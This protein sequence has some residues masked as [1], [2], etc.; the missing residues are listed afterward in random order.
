MLI[1]VLIFFQNQQNRGKMTIEW[2]KKIT[3][4]NHCNYLRRLQGAEFSLPNP[5]VTGSSPV[6]GTI[7]INGLEVVA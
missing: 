2:S 1:G 4:S 5:G 7:L 6:G 3:I